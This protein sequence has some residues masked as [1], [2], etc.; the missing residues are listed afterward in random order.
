MTTYTNE[1]VPGS[2]HWACFLIND[3]P[4][5]LTNREIRLACAWLV[6]NV[7]P[8]DF[9]ADISDQYFSWSYGLHCDD[10]TCSGGDLVDYMICRP[11][12]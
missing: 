6:R 1:I 10:D 7:G 2:A 4:S 9:I 11:K 12:P 5:G 3:D 8:D